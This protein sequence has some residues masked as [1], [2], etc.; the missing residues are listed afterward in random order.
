MR[1]FLR[2][3]SSK[4]SK[5]GKSRI[6]IALELFTGQRSSA[7]WTCAHIV[8]PIVT[9]AIK[10]GGSAFSVDESKLREKF[11]NVYWRRG[12]ANVLQGIA[13]Y[14]VKKP[15]TP[16]APFLVV[17]NFTQLCN[18]RCKHCYASAGNTAPDELT[19]DEA[20]KVAGKLAD[21]G[22]NIIAF[23]G[24][25]PLMR[26][27]FFEVLKA[28]ADYGVFTAVATNATLITREVAARL[29]ESKAGYIQISLDGATPKTHDGFRGVP[30]SFEKA[31]RGIKNCVEQ[32]V[33][34]EVSSTATKYNYKE[35]GDIINLCENLNVD[36]WMM[37]NFV[38]TGRGKFI[39]ENDLPPEERE[40]LLQTLWNKLRTN[41]KLQVLTTAPQY[42]RVALQMEDNAKEKSEKIIVPTHFYNPHLH[43]RLLGLS[44]FIGGCGAGRFYCAIEPNGLITPC[45]FFKL[46]IGNIRNDN[47]K[48]IWNNNK[49]LQDLRDRDKLKGQSGICKYKY[50]CGGCRARAYG[51]FEDYHAP[52][53]GCINNIEKWQELLKEP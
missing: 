15:F 48:E 24:G 49:V 53:P 45:V 36:W 26:K 42:A 20:L 31:V 14:G 47:F 17:W 6:E 9:R 16:A 19:P 40:E 1:Y 38:P 35:M 29:K 7:C 11:E 37:Y 30:Q 5:D 39:L 41:P 4:C 32:G 25:E 27:D 13:R 3:F 43:G 44:E 23:S 22:V 8:N 12:L 50:V 51:Y 28:S 34:V 52:D 18:L 21:A 2:K 46:N 10:K 33:F